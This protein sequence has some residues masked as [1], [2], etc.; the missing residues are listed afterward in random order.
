MLFNGTRMKPFRS[1]LI[2]LLLGAVARGGSLTTTL[3][4]PSGTVTPGATL[5]A[6]VV[7]LNSDSGA[8]KIENAAVIGGTLLIGAKS[9]PVSFRSVSVPQDSVAAG[10]F[11]I[12]RYSLDLPVDAL[13][14][15]V[16]E[17]TARD[18]Q[19]SRVAVKIAA[20]NR[21]DQAQEPK[22]QLAP[23]A[24]GTAVAN[25][26][27]TVLGR[28]FAGRLS[29]HE[30]IYFIYGTGPHSAKFQFSFKYKL[31]EFS[32][33]P[34]STTSNTLQFGYTQRSLWDLNANSSPFYDTSYL[35]ELFW[36]WFRLPA[37]KQ[38]GN[39][40]WNGFQIGVLHESNGRDGGDSRSLNVARFAT[41]LFI[42][43][44]SGRH[45]TLIPE[46]YSYL[47]RLSENRSIR[48]Y[49]GNGR[50]R[51]NYGR[52]NGLQ[53]TFT[54]IAGEGF[55]HGSVQFD[56]TSPVHVPFLDAS[57][58]LLVQYFNGYGE[59]LRAFDQKSEAVR[60][61]FSLVR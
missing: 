14:I 45:L 16:I 44:L 2:V 18:I 34:L 47:G 48:D 17:L 53:L 9:W 38:P 27:S 3:V 35:P 52:A 8:R 12:A 29:A 13:G 20:E 4:M 28:T 24:A 31:A 21:V 59:S 7:A 41:V 51:A 46:V 15:G 61:G 50:L 23:A 57:L 56:L 54:G 36:E 25:V 37:L 40:S 42:G 10:G 19:P 11:A 1:A 32:H 26:D 49:R 6:D 43:P 55:S 33:D 39:I 22:P 5:S 30:P 58:F 60:A